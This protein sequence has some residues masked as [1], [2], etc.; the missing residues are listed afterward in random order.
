MSIQQVYA[1]DLSFWRPTTKKAYD[2]P[3][4]ASVTQIDGKAKISLPATS[5]AVQRENGYA[6]YLRYP[7]Y[8]SPSLI[9]ILPPVSRAT[10]LTQEY[11]DSGGN[12]S[13]RVATL[14]GASFVNITSDGNP[15]TFPDVH[16]PSKQVG[17]Y[18][19]VEGSI[20]GGTVAPRSVTSYPS[21]NVTHVNVF[22]QA[23][24]GR[25]TTANTQTAWLV[26]G[27]SDLGSTAGFDPKTSIDYVLMADIYSNSFPFIQITNIGSA[28]VRLFPTCC[29]IESE[30]YLDSLFYTGGLSDWSTSVPATIIVGTDG[31]IIGVT[32][33]PESMTKAAAI[34]VPTS[35]VILVTGGL[36]NALTT[37]KDT[38]FFFNPIDETWTATAS[39]MITARRDHQMIIVDG[40]QGSPSYLKYALVV[41]GK[42][43]LFS[44]IG[45]TGPD[46]APVGIPINKCEIINIYENNPGNVPTSNFYPTGSM[47]YARYAFGMTKLND[48]RIL[49]CGGIGNDSNYPILDPTA[50]EYDYELK[51][52]EIYDSNSGFWTPVQ[53]MKEAHSYCVCSYVP[54]ANKVYV[55][56]G[57]RSHLIEYLD[58]NTMTWHSSAFALFDP[59]VGGSPLSMNFGV[60][61]LIGG[62]TYDF[63]TNT[64]SLNDHITAGSSWN[65]IDILLPKLPE[66]NRYDGL[67]GEWRIDSYDAGDDTWTLSSRSIG[68]Y[69]NTYVKWS[70]S[71]LDSATIKFILAKAVE[72]SS[73]DI[74]G[75]FSFDLEQPFGISGTNLNL[76]QEI[77]KGVNYS[78]LTV[79]S[80]ASSIEEGYLLFNYG[81]SDQIGPVRCFGSTDD[82]TLMIDSGFK[83]PVDLSIDSKVNVL[84]QRAA[85][86]QNTPYGSFWL[87]ASNAGRAT[88][89]DLLK[90]ISAAG[91]ELN[92]AT[93]YPGD[94]GLGNE[95]YPVIDNYKISDIVECFSR[96]DVDKEL[97]EARGT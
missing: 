7:F 88:A 13:S 92:I 51:T 49:V 75:P 96:D 19:L 35:G 67:N 46:I 85:Y 12:V 66:Y 36:D 82:T 53:S 3:L 44:N 48:G 64:F 14:Y 83:F 33:C 11:P 97:L 25:K 87:T 65:A 16:D 74:V 2:N 26:G 29:V 24:P 62:G 45:Q 40:Y 37:S 9:Y 38:G 69:T 80:G 54:E 41:G 72:S 47:S 61:A 15:S 52:C 30:R 91:I 17:D 21:A 50:P 22:G 5:Q 56:G 55:Y 81:Y 39:T 84:Y 20:N 31:S 73:S 27:N 77:K 78:T 68:D 1:K 32:D 90:S 28:P 94:R 10:Y 43:G 4:W 18:L 70:D 86:E 71:V 34:S 60:S 58:L 79:T 23:V 59:I 93:R 63:E 42:T 57:Y 6:A 76:N 89:I 95:G 8:F